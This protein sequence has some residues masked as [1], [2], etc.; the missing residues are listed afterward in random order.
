V[1]GFPQDGPYDVQAARIRSEQ[2]LRSADIYGNGTVVRE[3]FSLRSLVRPG[4]SGGPLVSRSG[5]VLG[6]VF[7]ASVTDSQTGYALTADQV[8]QAAA[9]GVTHQG[10]VDTGG[11]AGTS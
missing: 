2:R 10:S 7:A 8:A 1:L 4:N 11:C 9:D 5:K 6:V 3:V